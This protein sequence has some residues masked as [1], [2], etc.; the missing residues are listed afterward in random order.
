MTRARP[1]QDGRPGGRAEAEFPGFRYFTVSA[2]GERD[3]ATADPADPVRV[4]L[5]KAAPALLSMN[6]LLTEGAGTFTE[7]GSLVG[8]FSRMPW[9]PGWQTVAESC[10]SAGTVW[11][12]NCGVYLLA[13]WDHLIGSLLLDNGPVIPP[14]IAL[15]RITTRGAWTP[16]PLPE[17]RFFRWRYRAPAARI[18]ELW[19]S[20][21]ALQTAEALSAEYCVPV[22]T[23]EH[24][25]TEDWLRSLVPWGRAVPVRGGPTTGAHGGPAGR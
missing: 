8:P 15:A 13:S 19:L 22:H 24:A 2:A 6:G 9:G 10:P 23:S 25:N 17:G 4:A 7:T 5:K 1:R 12:C 18:D 11:S 21:G 20:P 16:D 14:S 3:H